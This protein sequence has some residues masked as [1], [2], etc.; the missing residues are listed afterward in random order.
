[1]VP[2]PPEGI[3][4]PFYV[5]CLAS[6]M[7][8]TGIAKA[9]FGGGIG[10]LAVP[11]FAAAL[12]ASRAIG[13]LLPLL[14]VADCFANLHHLKNRS[15]PHLRWLLGGAFVGI[16]LGT[17]LF[18]VLRHGADADLA[19]QRLNRVL[20]LVVGGIC[21]ALV[22]V[23]VYRLLGG[24]VPH[25][26]GTPLAGHLTGAVAGL[27]STLAHS[28]GPIISI[29]LLERKL[30]KRLLVGTAAMFFLLVNLAKVP[31][32]IAVELITLDTLRQSLWVVPFI[33]LGTLL[34][35]WMHKH[36][37]EKPFTIIMYAGAAAAAGNMIAKGLS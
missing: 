10:I 14:I 37:A 32:F 21:L 16:A 3:S 15:M 4:L 11:L 28:A 30:D 31:T 33:P 35:Y 36:V 13:M 2:A 12:P 26:P 27:V 19:G 1:M 6:A 17:L 29:Y 25:V 5:F 20:N 18:F 24:W 34:G 22:L 8:I 7:L 9:G 23:Q